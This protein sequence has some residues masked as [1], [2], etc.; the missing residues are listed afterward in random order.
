[1]IALVDT[2]VWVAHLRERSHQLTTLLEQDRV[3]CHPLI[4]GELACGNLA[5]RRAILD[6]LAALPVSPIAEYEDVLSF[7]DTHGLFGHGLG[8][9]DVHLLVSAILGRCRLLTHDIALKRA[10]ATFDIG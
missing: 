5:N 2:S 9:I 1:M 10:A 7:V 3:R 4:V 8:W 6:L